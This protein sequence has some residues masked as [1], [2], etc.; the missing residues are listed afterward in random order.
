MINLVEHSH[1]RE[2]ICFSEQPP[3]TLR[4]VSDAGV[5]SP[6][7]LCVMEIWGELACRCDR[8]MSQRNCGHH[9][10]A[11]PT[12]LPFTFFARCPFSGLELHY[13]SM[14]PRLKIKTANLE[15]TF[16]W[17][18]TKGWLSNSLRTSN[19]RYVEIHSGTGLY[20]CSVHEGHD[21]TICSI[22]RG[23][24]NV[25]CAHIYHF[26]WSTLGSGKNETHPIL[27]ART[28]EHSGTEW[29]AQVLNS[30]STGLPVLPP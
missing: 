29:F 19:E 20:I 12:F 11:L 25:G 8:C 24:P 30:A 9:Q 4:E 16:F 28:S 18:D 14:G 27:Q 13:N 2:T 6:V 3:S 10:P 26:H 21:V 5:C 22:W 23:L 1:Q 15:R 7:E 17:N